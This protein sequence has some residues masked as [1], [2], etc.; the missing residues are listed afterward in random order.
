MAAIFADDLTFTLNSDHLYTKL[1]FLSHNYDNVTCNTVPELYFK[2]D[3][4]WKF[5]YFGAEGVYK[6]LQNIRSNGLSELFRNLWTFVDK[7]K[8]KEMY[9]KHNEDVEK[10]EVGILQNFMVAFQLYIICIVIDIVLFISEQLVSRQLI[11]KM[12][13]FKVCRDRDRV[14]TFID[15]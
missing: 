11:I 15:G 13:I 2:R 1:F 14:V 9:K 5:K 8:I 4:A 3:I 6:I 10:K 12:N 7:K